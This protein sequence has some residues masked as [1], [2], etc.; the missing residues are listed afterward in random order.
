MTSSPP[1]ANYPIR[2]FGS[3]AA[4]RAII[5]FGALALGFF[6]VF[7][8][9]RAQSVV[10]QTNDLYLFADMGRNIAEGRGF[11][12]TDGP[13]TTRRGPL[14]PGLIA[15]LYVI[16]G[17]KPAAIL[18]LH[19]FLYAGTCVLTF[20]IGRRVFSLR[21]GL[22]A[23]TIVALHPMVLRY[24]PDIQ[25]ETLLTFLYT[26]T[27]YRSIRLVEEESL[28]NGLLFGAA[29]GAAC[30]VKGVALPY[31]ALFAGFYLLSRRGSRSRTGSLLP[32]WKPIAAMLAAMAIIILPWTYR[33]YKVTGG[34]FVLIS[35]NASGEFLRGYVFAQPRYY[36]LRDKP[37]VVGEAEANEME[38]ELF[39]KQGLVWERDEAETDRVQDVAAKAAVR[40]HPEAF[41]KKFFIGLFMFW[42]VVTTRLNSLFVAALAVA[43]WTLAV[44]GWMRGRR[45]GYGFW[46]LFL[47]I[48]SMNFIYAAILALG[49]YSAPC[50]PSLMVLAAFGV[51][52]LLPGRL[53]AGDGKPG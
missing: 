39:R 3:L 37:Y 13:L 10:A 52:S 5:F 7:V 42:Y 24:V 20:E 36:L 12:A 48:A 11:R 53:T 30:M 46:L 27:V 19:C 25:V 21:T 28:S 26:L 8:V 32:G 23:A 45:Q 44:V 14:Y 41:V 1:A 9:W 33:N 40:E 49:R 34:H 15:L 17:V 18:V 47:P 43:G 22:L 38:A 2:R 51:E 35:R 6:M 29:A 4:L 31:A 16:F 50:I